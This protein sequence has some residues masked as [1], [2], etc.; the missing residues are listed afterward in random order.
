MTINHISRRNVVASII[1]TPVLLVLA[2]EINAQ[3]PDRSLPAAT[4]TV[5]L[6]LEQRHTIKE[7]MKDVKVQPI[8]GDAPM[9]VGETVPERVSM[10]PIPAEIGQRVPQVKSHV[11]FIKDGHIV[12]VS[13][14][15]NT[16]ADVIE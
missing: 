12:L 1:A 11:F 4:P 10:Q 13:P 14:K 2:P 9:K 16:I 15:D 5:N 3:A 8:S 6:T 7:L